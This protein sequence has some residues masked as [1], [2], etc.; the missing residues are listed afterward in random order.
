LRKFL[1]NEP[2]HHGDAAVRNSGPQHHWRFGDMEPVRLID[3]DIGRLTAFV[4]EQQR[5]EGFEP[6]PP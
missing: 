1:R 2:N 5:V 6:C 3:G 4:R